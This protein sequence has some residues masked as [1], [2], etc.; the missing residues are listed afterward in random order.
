MVARYGESSAL[1]VRS[2]AASPEDFDDDST[3]SVTMPQRC[4]TRG[5]R[6]RTRTQ[7]MRLELSDADVSA[8]SS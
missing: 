1:T 7:Q 2:A 5:A 3:A 6:T 8:L 4:S